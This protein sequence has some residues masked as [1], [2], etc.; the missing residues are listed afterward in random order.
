MTRA[1]STERRMDPHPALPRKRERV[2]AR[3]VDGTAADLDQGLFPRR[4]RWWRPAV[5]RAK[6]TRHDTG[7]GARASAPDREPLCPAGSGHVAFAEAGAC[8]GVRRVL[9]R[10]DRGEPQGDR[11]EAGTGIA[12]AS[13]EADGP[14]PPLGRGRGEVQ[15]AESMVLSG[16]RPCGSPTTAKTSLAGSRSDFETRLASARVTAPISL[17][18]RS[19]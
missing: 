19:K 14:P 3:R 4:G 1:S 9:S 5:T 11:G 13:K 18:R 2:R 17:G 10:R 12:A 7:S 15:S 16:L 8:G 6:R